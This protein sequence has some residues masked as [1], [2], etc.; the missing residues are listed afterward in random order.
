MYHKLYI[1]KN[2]FNVISCEVLVLN[3]SV[4]LHRLTHLKWIL[5]LCYLPFI[6]H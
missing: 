6:S 4:N 2:M 1:N 3:T 5:V